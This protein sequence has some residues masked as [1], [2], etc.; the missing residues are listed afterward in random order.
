MWLCNS[1]EAIEHKKRCKDTF[2]CDKCQWID[3]AS[4]AMEEYGTEIIIETEPHPLTE[5][6]I[7]KFGGQVE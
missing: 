7:E 5:A 6:V 3:A 2:T 4:G 1:K